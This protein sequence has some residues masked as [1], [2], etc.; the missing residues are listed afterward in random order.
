[1]DFT[2]ISI[3]DYWAMKAPSPAK[4]HRSI[5]REAYQAAL[6]RKLAGAKCEVCG[7]PIWAVGSAVC[8]WDGCFTCITG[9]SDCSDAYELC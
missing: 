6:D 4:P 2:Y 1:M 9:E 8:G 7:Q 5:S 3:D